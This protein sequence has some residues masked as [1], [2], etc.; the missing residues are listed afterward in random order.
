[1]NKDFGLTRMRVSPVEGLINLSAGDPD[2]DQPEFINRTVYEAMKAGYTHYSF[3]GEP[4]F[5]ESIAKY[6]RKYGVDVDPMTQ[7]SITSGGSQGIF[8][9]FSAFLNPGDEI[10]IMDPAYQGY[11]QPAEYFGAKL[12]RAKQKKDREGLFRPNFESI[13]NAVT[14]DT[15]A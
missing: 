4:D 5:K 10:I 11:N 2:F 12:V 9:A 8:L 15:K 14:K 13:E 1:M 7:V 6:Y 3:T